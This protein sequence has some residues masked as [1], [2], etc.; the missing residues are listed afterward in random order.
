MT[1]GSTSKILIKVSD[2]PMIEFLAKF[3]FKLINNGMTYVHRN[4]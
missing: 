1:R 2:M 4:L 3:Y